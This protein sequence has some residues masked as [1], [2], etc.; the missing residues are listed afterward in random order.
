MTQLKHPTD[1]VTVLTDIVEKDSSNS[2][3]SKVHKEM[4]YCNLLN[5]ALPVN[6]RVLGWTEVTQEFSARFSAKSRTYR[7]FFVQGN[8]NIDKMKLGTSYL[9]GEH[10]YRNFCKMDVVNVSNFVR[11]IYSADILLFQEIYKIHHYL[12]GC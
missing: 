4:D 5:K 3:I 1:S 6:I 7:Y 11:S 9:L 8:L 10:D 2:T 12:Y